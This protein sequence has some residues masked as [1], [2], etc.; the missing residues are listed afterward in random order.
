MTGYEIASLA[1]AF[2]SLCLSIWALV[3][4]GK[5]SSASIE[6]SLLDSITSADEKIGECSA[7]MD[8]LLAKGVENLND[9]EKTLLELKTKRYN[10]AKENYLNA[11]EEACAKYLD[12]KIDKKRFKKAYSSSVR[13]VVENQNFKKYFDPVTSKYKAILKVYDKWFNLEK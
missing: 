12:N 4:A 10:T 11:I 9:E 8:D 3:R 7:A 6:I 13:K 5:A 1:I 2:L